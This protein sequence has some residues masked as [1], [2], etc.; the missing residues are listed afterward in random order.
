VVAADA[1]GYGYS[2]VRHIAGQWSAS[3]REGTRRAILP[4]AARD[5]LQNAGKRCI[6]GLFLTVADIG[7]HIGCA[8]RSKPRDR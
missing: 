7:T 6:L 3:G 4:R 2:I 8:C 1:A 5:G